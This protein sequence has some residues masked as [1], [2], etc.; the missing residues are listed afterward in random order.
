VLGEVCVAEEDV[1][2]GM[3]GGDLF[4]AAA[5]A[6]VNASTEVCGGVAFEAAGGAFEATRVLEP[7]EIL[8]PVL[9]GNY[10]SG[11]SNTSSLFL[12]FNR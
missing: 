9:P 8:I 3:V 1:E 10:L 6:S 7:S 2:L 5:S 4:E 12:K 11:L